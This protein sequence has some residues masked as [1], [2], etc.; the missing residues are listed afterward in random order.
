MAGGS[1]RTDDDETISEI[2]IIP[3]VDIVLVLLIIF[4]VTAQFL[5]DEPPPPPPAIQVELPSA[6][7]G[8]E[9]SPGLLT[10]TINGKGELFQNGE[11]TTLEAVRAW[12][13]AQPGP[14]EKIETVLAADKSISHGDVITVIDELRKLGMV[15]FAI[16]TKAQDIR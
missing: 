16:N 5:R 4:M 9:V 3:L 10:L 1:I 2:N 11:L 7:T 14:P 6:A 12:V 13:K 15:K 8:G